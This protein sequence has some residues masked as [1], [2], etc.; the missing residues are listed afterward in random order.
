M[1]AGFQTSRPGAGDVAQLV[2][3]FPG[4]HKDLGEIANTAQNGCGATGL[5]SQQKQGDQKFKAVH[6]YIVRSR[7]A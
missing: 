2:G 4:M 5:S 7:L 1:R 6:S 3:Y